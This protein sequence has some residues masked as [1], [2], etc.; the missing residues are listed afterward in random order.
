MLDLPKPT[1][2]EL[3]GITV[4]GVATFQL[5]LSDP[6]NFYVRIDVPSGCQA[7][8]REPGVNPKD[9]D[10]TALAPCA[11]YVPLRVMRQC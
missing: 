9:S 6:G 8:Q 3:R 2:T 10:L 5:R 11:G 4:D 1:E 7:V